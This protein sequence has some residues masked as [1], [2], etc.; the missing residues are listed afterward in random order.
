MFLCEECYYAACY[1]VESN[2]AMPEQSPET[3][4]D[5]SQRSSGCCCV[6]MAYYSSVAVQ[7]TLQHSSCTQ[8][9]DQPTPKFS[10]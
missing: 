6:K 1:F 5:T 10:M 9:L 2:Y 7:M 3:G 8:P 4:M